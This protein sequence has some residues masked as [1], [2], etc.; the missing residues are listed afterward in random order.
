MSDIKNTLAVKNKKIPQSY[1]IT[2]NFGNS[3]LFVRTWDKWY[4]IAKC[5]IN[6]DG[7]IDDNDG[8]VPNAV[9]FHPEEIAYLIA[10]Q[11]ERLQSLERIELLLEEV[12]ALR[13]SKSKRRA[14]SQSQRPRRLQK[15]EVIK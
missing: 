14:I 7:H 10:E 12:I 3:F 15:Q 5:E 6:T 13:L 1:S 8:L 9:L 2:D 11:Q 4:N